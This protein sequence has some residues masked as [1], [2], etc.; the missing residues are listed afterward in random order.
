MNMHGFAAVGDF[1]GLGHR[2]MRAHHELDLAVSVRARID[3]ARCSECGKCLIACR[4]GGYGAI[5]SPDG[6]TAIDEGKCVGCSLCS[7]VCPSAAIELLR[8]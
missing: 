8:R 2:R 4:D 5:G 6:H 3:K 1:I 7:H